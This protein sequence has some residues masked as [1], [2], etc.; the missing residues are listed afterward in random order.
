MNWIN[1]ILQVIGWKPQ[2]T[3]HPVPTPT[4]P[5]GPQPSPEARAALVAALNVQR[6]ANGGL[7]PYAEHTGLDGV[8]QGYA[9]KMAAAGVLDHGNWYQRIATVFPSDASSEDIAWNYPDIDSVVTGWMN[10]P[11]HRA[12]ILGPYHWVGVGWAPGKNND[13]FWCVDFAA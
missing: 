11:G 3:P 12:N 10:S 7:P 2:P 9:A 4:P 5:P 13:L 1:F 8:A 6:A